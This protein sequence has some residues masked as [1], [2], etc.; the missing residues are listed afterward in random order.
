MKF[1]KAKS[2][3]GTKG[4]RPQCR[5]EH[6]EG[7]LERS[8]NR[9][10]HPSAGPTVRK[11]ASAPWHCPEPAANRNAHKGP[12]RVD[13][14]AARAD[15]ATNALGS[16]AE[17]TE[18][19]STGTLRRHPRHKLPR[20][21]PG[22]THDRLRI[23]GLYRWCQQDGQ[24][25]LTV[26]ACQFSRR[27]ECVVCSEPTKKGGGMRRQASVAARLKRFVPFAA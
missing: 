14:I 4:A 5:P 6:I 23:G 27:D 12:G 1:Q 18:G 10:A 9:Y 16:P 17:H 26:S 22:L 3:A 21:F 25:I 2:E 13:A 11:S 20:G 19:C 24:A 15:A 8:G 7:R